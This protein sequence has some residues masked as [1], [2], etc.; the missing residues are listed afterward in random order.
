MDTALVLPTSALDDYPIWSPDSR[1]VAGNVMGT[2]TKV[3]LQRISLR[4]ATWRG[5]ERLGVIE[6]RAAVTPLDPTLVK[7]W[8]PPIEPSPD[9]AER[10]PIRVEFSRKGLSTVLVVTRDGKPPRFVSSSD[11][12]TCGAPRI[13]PDG[14]MV[15]FI[16]ETNGLLVM[17]LDSVR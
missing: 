3:D 14:H 6:N 11:F 15:A 2:W 7:Q 5:G 17:A 4:A 16:C 12:E 10:G 1:Y 13:S 9:V 8:T